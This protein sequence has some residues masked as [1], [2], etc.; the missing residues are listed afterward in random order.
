MAHLVMS[1]DLAL[2]RIEEALALFRT[3]DD[4]LDRGGEIIKRY[5]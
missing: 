4:A 3:G 1:Y 2:A 5:G